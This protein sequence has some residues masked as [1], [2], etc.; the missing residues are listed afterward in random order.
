M[1]RYK[2]PLCDVAD[3]GD[4]Y[5]VNLE[6]P[7][8]D[9][10]KIDVKATKNSEFQ[11]FNLKSPKKKAEIM[12]IMREHLNHFIIKYLSPKKCCLQKSLQKLIM[13]F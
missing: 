3:K 10:D 5:E 13:E 12:F 2:L 1:D 9:K 11:D 4:K 7:G 6:I 8:I